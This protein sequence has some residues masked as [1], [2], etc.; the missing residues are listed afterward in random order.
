MR[1]KHKGRWRLARLATPG[2][3]RT[4]ARPPSAKVCASGFPPSAWCRKSA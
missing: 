1:Q 4:G 2:L 3:G